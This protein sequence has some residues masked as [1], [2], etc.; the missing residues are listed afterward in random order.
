VTAAPPGRWAAINALYYEKTGDLQAKQDAFR[1]LNYSTYYAA[2]DGKISCCGT[3]YGDEGYW[4]SDGY[5]DYLGHLYWV[6]GAIPEWAPKHQNHLLHSSSV[7]PKVTYGEHSVEYETFDS[8]ATEVLRLDFR[9][10]KVTAGGV[11]AVE[12]KDLEDQGYTLQRLPDGDYVV[13]VRHDTS[14]EVSIQG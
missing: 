10:R 8:A 2:S 14:V 1:S 11:A 9:P 7:V 6:M 12:R 3:D 13:R 4:W 5:A